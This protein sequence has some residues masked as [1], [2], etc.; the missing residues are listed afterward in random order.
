MKLL[1]TVLPFILHGAMCKA[2]C[3]VLLQIEMLFTCPL[4]APRC[5]MVLLYDPFLCLSCRSFGLATDLDKYL[6]THELLLDLE[7]TTLVAGH[8]SR[9]GTKADVQAAQQY[10]QDAIQFIREGVQAKPPQ[11]VLAAIPPQFL[12]NPWVIVSEIQKAVIE[13]CYEKLLEAWGSRLGGVDVY[14]RS[15]CAVMQSYVSVELGM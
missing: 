12:T 6:A 11:A 10:A 13:F 5:L 15:H 9:P 1:H 8:L 2:Y 7:W 14:G 3:G 4:V